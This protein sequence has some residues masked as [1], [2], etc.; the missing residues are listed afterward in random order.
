MVWIFQI[1]MFAHGLSNKDV[2]V[3]FYNFFLFEYT[4]I[5]KL[6]SK[7]KLYT[8]NVNSVIGTFHSSS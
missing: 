2:E 7:L 1:K 3:H 5:L 8:C 4:C 6:V